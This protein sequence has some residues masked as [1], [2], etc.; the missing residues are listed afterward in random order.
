MERFAAQ[1]PILFSLGIVALL[2]VV[3]LVMLGAVWVTGLA[4]S[5]IDLPLLVIQAVLTG[6][7]LTGLGWWRRTGFTV[8]PG[9]RDFA[10]AALPAALLIGPSV[11]VGLEFPAPPQAA[12]LAIVVLLV[13]LHEEGIFRGIILTSL[14]PLGRYQ[15]ALGSALL[16]AIIHANSLLVGRDPDFVLS[17]VIASFLGG[18]GLA[19][20]K[21]RMMSIWPLV[22]LHAVNDF[23]Q[24]SATAGLAAAEVG[25]SVVLIK[26]GLSAAVGLYGLF[27]LWRPL[28]EPLAAR[29]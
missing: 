19:A 4:L 20:M 26:I 12:M 1:R 5:A 16:F 22:L 28:P 15:A 29:P 21:L 6:L 14:A 8:P 23:L 17:Q 18:F 10:L 11:A 7:L 9:A 25:T 13:A 3:L 27:L 24:F 2:E